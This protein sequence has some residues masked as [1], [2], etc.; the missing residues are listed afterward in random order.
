MNS[1]DVILPGDRLCR[2][3][4]WS[5]A[6]LNSGST[7]FQVLD[8]RPPKPVQEAAPAVEA[9]SPIVS[10]E[11]EASAE[12][13]MASAPPEAELPLPKET[14]VND[15]PGGDSASAAIDEKVQR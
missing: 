1:A 5:L 13:A 15:G 12:V 7:V 8:S 14:E 6:A 10:A 9:S 3:G 4:S 2:A 11:A